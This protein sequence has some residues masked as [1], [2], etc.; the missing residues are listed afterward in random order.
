[1]MCEYASTCRYRIAYGDTVSGCIKHSHNACQAH[2][3]L[4]LTYPLV[5]IDKLVVNKESK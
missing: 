2:H 3:E 4:K 1:M 5:F